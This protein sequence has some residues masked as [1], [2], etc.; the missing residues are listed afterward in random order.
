MKLIDYVAQ[1]YMLILE[2]A[3]EHIYLAG[4]AV[5]L[6]CAVGIPIGFMITNNKK[7]ANIVVGI[8][9]VIQTIPSL[10][11]FAFA[12][13]IF[14]IGADN[15]IFALFLYALL[16]IIKNTLIGIRNVDPAIREAAH[17]TLSLSPMTLSHETTLLVLLE[18]LYRFLAVLYGLPYPK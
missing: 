9:N 7:L 5:L 1:N 2:K 12:L 3:G 8:A 11:L 17:S 14:G 10:A 4:I 6:A 15:A 18:Q 13:S 16:P